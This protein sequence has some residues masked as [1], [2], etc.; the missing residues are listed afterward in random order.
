MFEE[1][2]K[3][4]GELKIFVST[5]M[6]RNRQW[7]IEWKDL[8]VHTQR[9]ITIASRHWR[10]VEFKE[11]AYIHFP[12]DTVLQLAK[13]R[14]DVIV[15]G[16][17][18]LRTAQALLYQL[19]FRNVSFVPW[20][21]L[22]EHTERNVP[23]PLRLARRLLLARADAVITNGASATKYIHGL[24]VPHEKIFE[25]TF[26]LAMSSYQR[27][28]LP[29]PDLAARRL[30]YVGRLVPLKGV[31]E[32]AVELNQ[33]CRACPDEP[34][35]MWFIGDGPLRGKLESL[36]CPD[37]LHFKFFGHV[38]HQ[39]LHS[40]YEQCGIFVFPTFTDTWGMVINESLAS[41]LVVLGSCYSQAVDQLVRDGHNGWVFSPDNKA[42]VRE[43]IAKALQSP[44]ASLR[45]MQANARASIA[46]LT[47][48]YSGQRMLS[49]IS[50][51]LDGV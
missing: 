14:P 8:D 28:T 30:A 4:V 37:N 23:R 15:S 17:L 44:I 2:R 43:A 25:G 38:P 35:E 16:E 50:Y 27:L 33:H 41:G 3:G 49:A 31:L 39:E 26:S 47:P 9:S 7:P 32:F 36:T 18:G 1:I 48:E 46:F 13:Y 40:I 34:V 29:K 11:E 21:S 5:G 6:E 22:S 42:S 10:N 19:C 51:S 20:V 24:G 45:Q 12:Y